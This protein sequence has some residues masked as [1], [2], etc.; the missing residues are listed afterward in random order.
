MFLGDIQV[1]KQD[2]AEI[3]Q[4]QGEVF[5]QSKFDGILGLVVA[6]N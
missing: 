1:Q 4:E 3:V 5:E 6:F 2:F